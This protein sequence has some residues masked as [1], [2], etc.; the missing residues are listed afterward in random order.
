[1]FNAKTPT[2]SRA[3][4]YTSRRDDNC[5]PGYALAV[6]VAPGAL[7]K[8][9]PCSEHL[10]KSAAY[11]FPIQKLDLINRIE[12]SWLFS[13]NQSQQTYGMINY[14]FG[15]SNLLEVRKLMR[16]FIVGKK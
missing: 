2:S 4:L 9:H 11:K 7:P 12:S 6:L 10:V 16:Q 1:M 14:Q 15:K 5:F 8:N 3:V 13:L